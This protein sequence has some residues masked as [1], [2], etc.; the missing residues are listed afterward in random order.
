MAHVNTMSACRRQDGG[1]N[2]LPNDSKPHQN[3]MGKPT[4]KK[5][6]VPRLAV[7]AK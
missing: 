5:V 7:M 1:A 4:M 6:C 3:M 2:P